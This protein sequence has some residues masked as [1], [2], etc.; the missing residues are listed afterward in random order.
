MSIHTDCDDNLYAFLHN[1]YNRN[2]RPLCCVSSS[3]QLLYCTKDFL[4]FFTAKD[5]HSCQELWQKETPPTQ[6]SP[7][8][9]LQTLN[10]H[11]KQTLENGESHFTWHHEIPMKDLFHVHYSITTIHHSTG[12]IFVIQMHP[13]KDI[14]QKNYD[15]HDIL[16]TDVIHKSPTPVCMWNLE[17]KIIDCNNSFLV[18]LGLGS[19]AQCFATPHTFLPQYQNSNNPTEEN[20]LS[21]DILE[22]EIIK[23]FSTGYNSR[24][25]LWQNSQ[26]API[27]CKI[28]FLR[29]RYN[30]ENVVAV[31]CY[32]LREILLQQQKIEETEKIMSTMINS[33][34]LGVTIVDMSYNA[35]DCNDTAY[36]LFGF[37]N[38][39]D[40]IKEFFNLI[41]E[42]QPNGRLTTE[43]SRE[44]LDLCIENGYHTMEWLHIDKTGKA[45]PVET[46]LVHTHYKN[47]DM[48]IGYMRDLREI[49]TMQQKTSYAEQRNAI[50][51]ENVPLCIMFWNK[52]GE[53]I[54]C[55]KEVLR[56]F[57]YDNKKEYF[58]NLYNT[59]PIYQPNGRN[60]KEAVA[61]N[62]RITL[63]KGYH[64]FEWLHNT[65]EGELLPMEVILIRS[66]L[67]GEDIVVSYVKDLRD[68]KATQEL[69]K[70]AELRNTLM[71]DS[72]PLCVHFW[73]ENFRLIY[74]NLEGAN[75]FGFDSKEE[76]LDNIERTLPEFQP[77]GVR[78]KD[79]MTQM[80][81]T[82]FSTGITKGEVVCLHAFTEVEIP[83]EV[84]VMRTSYQGKQGL[85]AYLTDLR[86]HK[87]ML[88]EI[89]DNEKELR[90]AKEIAEKSTQAKSEFL[91][92]MSH[93]IRTPMNGILGLLHLLEQTTMSELQENYVK[94]SVFSANNLMR[95]INDILDFSKIEAGK[96]EMEEHPF[97]LQ[98]IC[99]D[100]MDL[101]ETIS[102]EKGLHL[103][104]HADTY[105]TTF[106]LG[107]ALRLKQVLFNLV[108][109]AIKFTRSGTVSLEIESSLR[110]QHELYCQFAVRD[111][112]IGLSPQQIDRLFS[113]FSQADSTISRKYG[114]TGLGLL[115]SRS[116]I[117]M[118]R[119]NVWVESELGKGSTFF[120]TAIFAIAD[121]DTAYT[122]VYDTDSNQK[123]LI[124]GKEGGH[125]LLAEDN[126]INQLVAQEILLAAGYSL[127]IVNNGQEALEMLKKNVYDAVL[128]DIQMPI[129]DG[130]TAAQNIRA[131]KALATLPIIA[132]SAHAMKGDKE[133]SISHGMNDHI[134][135]PIEPEKLYATLRQWISKNTEK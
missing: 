131:Q 52:E 64:R 17:K 25:W 93:E 78:T 94:K 122:D 43:Y 68:L 80:I 115:I 6:Y 98:G 4:N 116:I 67:D 59:S 103:H 89:A 126:E 125:L 15:S 133:K 97:T 46:T 135:K 53:M 40:F 124:T 65:S 56:T 76:Y 22:K 14:A 30:D 32:D 121:D 134:T 61:N 109:N 35:V 77:N 83:F 84:I 28:N 44:V 99:Q 117:T 95:I 55:N 54:D 105:A 90:V 70:E 91:A 112:G 101:Y 38:K 48:V 130:Y 106:L 8:S 62:H 36:K 73:D 60:S 7:N 107:D 31:F 9:F 110:N 119:G 86:E 51:S 58:K 21:I 132:M 24:K 104:I 108:S 69:V 27:P 2:P 41:P 85:I 10:F 11:C 102:A 16:Y 113:A 127:D 72:L 63:E 5:L 23:T 3:M 34:P 33:M 100:V 81:D 111:T 92:N 118:M 79:L 123:K 39:E 13:E 114:G 26:G 18:F 120:C 87:A 45:L 37:N 1:L 66:I 128:M 82:A 19:K 49:K 29:I 96:L 88:R 20:L 57:K 129:M 71:L 74:T 42:F 50:I 75:T 47:Q 12:P